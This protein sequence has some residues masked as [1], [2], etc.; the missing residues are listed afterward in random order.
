VGTYEVVKACLHQFWP[1]LT[2]KNRS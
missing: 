1:R 2:N